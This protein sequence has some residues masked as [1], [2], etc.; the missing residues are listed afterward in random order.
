MRTMLAGKELNFHIR[1]FSLPQTSGSFPYLSPLHGPP[2]Y[3][4]PTLKTTTLSECHH[5]L[6]DK[7][8]NG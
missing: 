1:K 5:V 6:Q 7:P 8:L 4:F 2:F 3:K